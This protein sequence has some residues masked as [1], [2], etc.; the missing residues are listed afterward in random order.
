MRRCNERGAADALDGI[1][2]AHQH[3]GRR[4]VRLAELTHVAEHVVDADVE[5][6]GPL[7]GALDDGAFGH[8]VGKRHA[9]LEHV[10]AALDERVHQGHGG[11]GA[12]VAGG[13]EGD[14]AGLVV[15]F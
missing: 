2:I 7:A 13:N 8:G 14:Q 3:H 1:G 15:R 10:G 9:Q 4:L 5:F 11:V 6:Q 12:G